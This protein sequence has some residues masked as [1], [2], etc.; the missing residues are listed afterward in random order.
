MTVR[1]KYRSTFIFE[2]GTLDD[3]FHSTTAPVS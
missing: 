1:P 2:V 3:D